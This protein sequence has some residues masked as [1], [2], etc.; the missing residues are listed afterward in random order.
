MLNKD[1]IIVIKVSSSLYS[2]FA[3]SL[4]K[5]PG[6]NIELNSIPNEKTVFSRQT[7][8]TILDLILQLPHGPAAY[9][10]E[11]PDLVETST[12]LATIKSESNHVKIN[13][14]TRSAKNE[15]LK[16]ARDEI[17]DTAE[18]LRASVAQ[19]NSYPGWYSDLNAPF[20]NLVKQRNIYPK[21]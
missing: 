10:K 14:S 7:T 19:E 13:L 4:E 20:L 9:S 15:E 12:N 16:K 11:I 8:A 21:Y 5:E 1:A 6:I 17:K 3:S 2:V 18:K